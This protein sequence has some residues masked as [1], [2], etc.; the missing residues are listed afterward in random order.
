M[1]S[2]IVFAVFALALGA[3]VPSY[4]TRRDAHPPGGAPGPAALAARPAASAAAGSRATIVPRDARRHFLVEARVD[5]RLI[6]FMV[7]TGAS[8][9]ALTVSDAAR[10]GIHPAQRDFTVEV[11]TANGSVRAAPARLDKV[12][13]G[14]LIVRDVAAVIL[15]DGALSDNLL[16]LSFLSRLR[17]FEYSDGRLVL[18]Q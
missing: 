18:E 2:V 15:P 1:R 5:G 10:L 7:D 14:D 8:V 11:R 16:G 3:L 13:V 9:I 4:L 6:N 17:R 12:E